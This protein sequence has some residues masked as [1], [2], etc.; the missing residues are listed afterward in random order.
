MDKRTIKVR[1]DDLP[2]RRVPR[3]AFVRPSFSF[4]RYWVESSSESTSKRDLSR[5]QSREVMGRRVEKRDLLCT[6][7]TVDSFLTEGMRV[8][9]LSLFSQMCNF[10]KEDG[11]RLKLGHR[12]S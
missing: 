12:I 5:L 8:V 7:K 2:E 10:Q 11:E 4:K 9:F 3:G 1:E 6:K